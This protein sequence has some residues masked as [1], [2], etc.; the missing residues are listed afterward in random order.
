MKIGIDM[1]SIERIEKMVNKFGT[2]ALNRF[3]NEDEQF[4]AKSSKTIAGFWVVKEAASKALGTGIGA[5]CGFKDVVISK[6]SKG[7]P[8][9]SFSDKVKDAFNINNSSVSITHDGGFAV[10]VVIIF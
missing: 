2:K 1:I 5:E 4:L 9:L 8:I 7:A 3:L 10:A 6:T